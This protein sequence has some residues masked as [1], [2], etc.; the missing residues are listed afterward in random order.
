MSDP[1][2]EYL[3]IVAGYL[4]GS[5][6]SDGFAAA[7]VNTVKTESRTQPSAVFEVVLEL[8]GA[9]EG[10]G[11]PGP[12]DDPWVT[13]EEELLAAARSAADRLRSLTAPDAPGEVDDERRGFVEIANDVS[14]P[15]AERDLAR[16]AY[17]AT[18]PLVRISTCPFTG[19]PV[20]LHLD[21]GGLDGPF[22][23]ARHP[24]RTRAHTLPRTVFSIAGALAL[25]PPIEVFDFLAIPGPGVPYVVPRLL[26][27]DGVVAVMRGVD[28]G[29]HRGVVICYFCPEGAVVDESLR[30][31]EWGA[32]SYWY[33]YTD[34]TSAVGESTVWDAYN[35][36]DVI[37]W[38]ESGKLRWIAPGDEHFDVV[39]GVACPYLDMGGPPEVQR[40]SEGIVKD[41]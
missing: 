4:D 39:E 8:F 20:M 34:G 24:A 36:Y 11:R 28:I 26:D 32:R 7:I 30:L 40:V 15:K 37:P 5:M 19:E 1:A 17:V 21:T 29:H 9:A 16:R 12:A 3:E 10:F 6:S 18:L 14:V 25:Q 38:L 23:E 13:T 27:S 33:G 2:S 41:V 22:W 35:E 31:N